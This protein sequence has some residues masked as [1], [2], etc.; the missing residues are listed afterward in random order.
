MAGRAIAIRALALG[1]RI[2]KR[3]LSRALAQAPVGLHGHLFVAARTR[4]LQ[5]NSWQ[6]YVDGLSRTHPMSRFVT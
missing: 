6:K 5:D 2:E 4:A 1:N 3:Q